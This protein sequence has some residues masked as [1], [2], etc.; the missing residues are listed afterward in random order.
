MLNFLA[1]FM[2][3]LLAHL[4]INK[5]EGSEIEQSLEWK[6]VLPGLFQ[7]QISTNNILIC[8]FIFENYDSD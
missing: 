8:T 5:V 2:A 6:W 3:Q 1:H 7:K 4:K